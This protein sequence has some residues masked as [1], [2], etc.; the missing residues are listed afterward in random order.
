MDFLSLYGFSQPLWF[1]VYAILLL[2]FLYV[3][4]KYTPIP[5]FIALDLIAALSQKSSWMY[6]AYI[7]LL[8]FLSFIIICMLAGPYKNYSIETQKKN[9]VDIE[10]VFDLSYSMIATDITPS[11]I[12]VAKKVLHDFIGELSSDRVGMVLFAG[13]AFASVPLTYDYDFL[14]EFIKQM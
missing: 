12:E 3:S 2:I 13:Q 6:R 14:Q 1:V 11:R 7:F 9:G 8:L 10:I 5:N 4:Q